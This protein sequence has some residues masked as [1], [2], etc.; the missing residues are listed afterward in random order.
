[1]CRARAFIIQS[2][3]ES[4]HRCSAPP[5]QILR[6]GLCLGACFVYQFEISS[7]TG[8][9]GH[10]PSRDIIIARYHPSRGII[11]RAASRI[12]RHHASRGI[13]HRA[14]SSQRGIFNRT[15]SS[16]GRHRHSHRAA[17]SISRHHASRGIIIE[18]HRASRGFIMDPVTPRPYCFAPP[19]SPEPEPALF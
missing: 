13:T 14:A 19:P 1:M 7:N 3:K 10:H 12:A 9:S 17:S 4:C 8:P 2:V 6:P 15:A 11:H 18:R 16:I 5:Q